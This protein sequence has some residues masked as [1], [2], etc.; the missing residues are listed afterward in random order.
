M[1][2]VFITITRD[3]LSRSGRVVEISID[4]TDNESI[5]DFLATPFTITKTF[6]VQ[7]KQ[8]AIRKEFKTELTSLI[9]GV[10]DT[11]E[12]DR[13]LNKQLVIDV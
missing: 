9:N 7:A 2:K 12:S 8:A 11:I 6:P 4:K 10:K 1:T 13:L 3:A 5:N